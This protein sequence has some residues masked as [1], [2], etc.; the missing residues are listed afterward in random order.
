MSPRIPSLYFSL[1]RRRQILLSPGNGQSGGVLFTPILLEG[2]AYFPLP[3]WERT[4]LR[5]IIPHPS[6]GPV[7]SIC[8]SWV[9]G[10]PRCGTFNSRSQV[11]S[12]WAMT[13]TPRAPRM[14]L[15]SWPTSEASTDPSYCC[16]DSIAC[17]VGNPW[18]IISNRESTICRRP[19]IYRRRF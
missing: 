11:P 18:S 16:S 13:G 6:L 8:T 14:K 9:G 1:K 3:L 5:G 12:L 7:F 15:R 4:E 19:S 17:A 2:G 10:A